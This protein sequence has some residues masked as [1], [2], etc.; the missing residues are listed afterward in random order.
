MN[1]LTE[2]TELMERGALGDPS[3][4]RRTVKEGLALFQAAE[5][6]NGLE[7]MVIVGDPPMTLVVLKESRARAQFENWE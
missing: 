5:T 2:A 4:L 3:V 6:E 7:L 1:R